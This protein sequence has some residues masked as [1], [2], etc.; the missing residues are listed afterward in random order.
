[1]LYY[2]TRDLYVDVN[3]LKPQPEEK[4]F[5]L[6]SGLKIH[7]WYF[8]SPVPPKAVVVFF[9]GNGQN[10]SIHFGSLFWLVEKGYDLAIFDYPGYGQTEGA[11]SPETTVEMGKEALRFVHAANPKLPLVV[12]GQSLGGAIATRSVWELRNEFLPALL[13]IDS[14][15]LSYRKV[16]QK[17]MSKNVLTWLFQPFPWLV[18]SDTWAPEARI[19]D[20]A[21]TPILVIHSRQDDIVPFS[22]GEETFAKAAQPKL[23]WIK[24]KGSHIQTFSD[25]DGQPLKEKLLKLLPK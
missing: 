2:P 19:K 7:G 21:G 20:L 17:I 25:P 22:L 10:R 11:P 5:H 14:S 24:E 4:T 18:L 1:M 15:F 13:V 6:K 23:F 12:Y 9:H 16:G 3:I 8:H